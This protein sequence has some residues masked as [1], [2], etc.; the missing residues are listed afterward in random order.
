MFGGLVHPVQPHLHSTRWHVTPK[1]PDAPLCGPAKAFQVLGKLVRHFDA[2]QVGVRVAGQPLLVEREPRK[3]QPVPYCP[4]H[5]ALAVAAAVVPHQA[6]VPRRQGHQQVCVDLVH[7]LLE[8]L[9]LA[10]GALHTTEAVGQP[11]LV[12]HRQ[13]LQAVGEV[14]KVRAAVQGGQLVGSARQHR[15]VRKQHS[16]CGRLRR[17]SVDPLVATPH[18]VHIGAATGL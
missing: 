7:Q 18:A 16:G 2:A 3:L 15:R 12:Q 11:R 9:L 6:A 14:E 17:S 5:R 4:W 1:V 10:C 13:R 8:L